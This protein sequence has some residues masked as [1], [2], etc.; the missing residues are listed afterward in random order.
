MV[1]DVL[2]RGRFPSQQFKPMTNKSKKSVDQELDSQD[3]ML[4]TGG[5]DKFFRPYSVS[6][7]DDKHKLGYKYINID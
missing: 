4:I 1:E 3:L 7:I 5:R 6:R 2:V